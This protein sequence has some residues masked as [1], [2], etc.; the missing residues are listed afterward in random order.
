MA[1]TQ[2]EA[3][4][5][6][7]ETSVPGP[8]TDISVRI[9]RPERA[10]HRRPLIV[11]LHGGGFVFGDLDGGHDGL[12]REMCNAADAIV[13]SVDYRLAPETQAPGAVEDAYAVLEW[14]VE[15]AGALGIDVERVCVAGD[16]A[17]GNLAG[18]VSI[19][20]Q[21]RGGPRI[22]AQ[23]LIYPVIA[24]DFATDSYLEYAEG[25][26]NTKSAMQWY[27]DQYA[28]TAEMRA[29]P[30]VNLLAA[31]S[32]SKLPT[33]IVVGA[34][35]DPLYS[36]GLSYAQALA[37][38]G[39]PVVH[40]SYADAFHGFLTIPAVPACARARRQL[41]DD[42]GD[43]LGDESTHSATASSYLLERTTT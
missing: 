6:V 38:A 12:C 3:V 24:P 31:V 2:V 13:I 4:A 33:T 19:L 9:Y 35:C 39:V 21:H 29:S 7:G 37:A 15:E 23:L 5:D 22:A 16:S 40:R 17:G 43:A 8:V 20:V 32:H 1:P 11:Y 27:W 42:L 25:Y 10:D 34:E 28:P 26:F 18:A 41:W 14:A 30:L 36:E